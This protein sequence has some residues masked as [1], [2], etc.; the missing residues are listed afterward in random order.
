MKM[1]VKTIICS[2]ALLISMSAF[3]K[4]EWNTDPMCTCTFGMPAPTIKEVTH[5]CSTGRQFSVVMCRQCFG[6]N[7]DTLKAVNESG[8]VTCTT[9]LEAI[10][11]VETGTVEIFFEALKPG[12]VLLFTETDI[13]RA[14]TAFGNRVTII[15]HYATIDMLHA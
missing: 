8:I 15:D 14:E 2:L 5:D 13:Q 9:D 12:K 6:E 4:R 11:K 1:S 7:Y 3:A 10:R